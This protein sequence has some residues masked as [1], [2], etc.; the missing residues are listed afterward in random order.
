MISP[1]SFDRKRASWS[2]WHRG[3]IVY[4]LGERGIRFVYCLDI[5]PPRLRERV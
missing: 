3:I 4:V 5:D 2:T 1:G